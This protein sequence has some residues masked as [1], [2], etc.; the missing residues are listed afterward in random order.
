MRFVFL[1]GLSVMGILSAACA[2]PTVIPDDDGGTTQPDG[3]TNPCT[4]MCGG[5]CADTKTDPQNCGKCGTVCPTQ[6]KC[7][8]GSCQCDVNLSRCGAACLDLKVDPQNCGKCGTA[9]GGDGGVIMG[10][11]MWGCGN[12]VCSIMCPQPKTECSGACVDTKTD[13]DN[14]GMCGTVCAQGMEQCLSGQCCKTGEVLCNAMCTNTQTDSM[15]CGMCG[16][17]CTG[18]TPVC[19]N[20]ACTAFTVVGVLGNN[21]FY[22]VPVS[23]AMTD[24]N[25][26][27]ACINAGLKVGC[28][29]SSCQYNDANCLV[30]QEVSCSSPMLA[31]A[32]KLG[33]NSPGGCQA[34]NGIYQNLGGNWVN[35]SSCGVEGSTW[36]AQG[37]TYMNRWALCV[38]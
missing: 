9:C 2:T 30:T 17:T 15:N 1:S 22:K 27:N 12:G 28:N 23:G 36:C 3:S 33:C 29:A 21:T 13:N 38:Q 10:G 19:A 18:N 31:L 7:V 26:H 11:G 24:V 16:K 5:Q 8:Q 37:S 35:G 32:Q 4:T 20:G 25:T 14:C 34:L 6:S